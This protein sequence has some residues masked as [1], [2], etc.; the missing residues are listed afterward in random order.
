[1]E[2]FAEQLR[3]AAPDGTPVPT[4]LARPRGAGTFPGI[5]LGYEFWGMLETPP[6][7]PHMRELA[8]RFAAAGY[9]AAIPD[10]YGARGKQP[11]MEGGVVVG[12]PP[13]D[14][15]ANDLCAGVHWLA[16][17]PYVDAAR[18]GVVGWCG[19]GRQ[20]LFLAARCPG[21][22]AAATLYGRLVNRP[23]QPG[24]SPI[25]LVD[26][27]LCPIFGAYGENDPS[28]PLAT[29][30]QFRD[31][32]EAARKIHEIHVFPNAGHAFMNDHYPQGYNADAAGEAWRLLVDFFD[33][34][35]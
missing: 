2:S 6:G 1:V 23:A 28:V 14:E 15:S 17:L 33:R 12:L 20:A 25:D 27:F 29:V 35:L 16:A 4:H 11:A 19:G 7:G 5:L 13:E 8:A 3:Y 30:L 10:F 21:I 34:R 9:V 18:V 24:P 31:A 32:L 22:K 26:G